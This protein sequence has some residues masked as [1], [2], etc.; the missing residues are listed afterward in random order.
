MEDRANRVSPDIDFLRLRKSQ[1]QSRTSKNLLRPIWRSERTP[2][3]AMPL[4]HF[5]RYKDYILAMYRRMNANGDRLTENRRKV[6]SLE[7]NRTM[8]HA[9]RIDS[10]RLG[11]IRTA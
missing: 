6:L 7:R 4:N 1:Y 11:W 3:G 8:T 2:F 9:Q 5:L 10:A